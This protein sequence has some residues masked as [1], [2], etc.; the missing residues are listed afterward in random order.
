MDKIVSKKSIPLIEARGNHLTVGRQIG[1]AAR[2]QIA[3]VLARQRAYL[4]AGVTWDGLL[5]RSRLYLAYSRPNFPDYLEELQG[6]AEG[7]GQPFEEV[8]LAM[9]EELWEASA[10][11]GCTDMAARGRATVDG[12]TLLAHTNDLAPESEA[13]LVIITVKA[14][15]EPEFIGISAGGIGISAGFNRSGLGLSGNQLDN[16][17]IRVGVPRLLVVRAILACERL[18]KAV[19]L[20]FL[21]QRASSYN[22]IIA[23]DN[24]EVYSMEGSAT[25]C[26]PIYI[27][28]DILAHAN[29]YTHPLMLKY[30][31]DP[32]SVGD[33][34]IR[35]RRAE[36][37]LSENYGRLSPALFQ[38]LLA[39]HANY[40]LSI[41]KHGLETV[42]VFSM[43]VDLE[44]RCAWIGR[45]RP[46]ETNYDKYSL[47]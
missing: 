17:D 10:W 47:P 6:I 30:E 43:I 29:H 27:E 45:G 19:D 32:S 38:E 18:G 14:A 40:P 26:Q 36:R 42:T 33:S 2:E 37:L 16:N 9:C 34:V 22:N 15:N 3:R 39:D 41:C 7:A 25:D 44:S 35:Q 24:G 8:Y 4:P 46:C 5:E 31:A 12:H 13:D 1:E 11:R 21:P 20:C 23:D 28:K